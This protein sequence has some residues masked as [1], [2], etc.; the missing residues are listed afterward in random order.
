LNL[1]ASAATVWGLLNIVGWFPIGPTTPEP[2]SST[3]SKWLR[4]VLLCVC[5]CASNYT[6]VQEVQNYNRRVFGYYQSLASV[7]TY[8]KSRDETPRTQP[9]FLSPPPSVGPNSKSPDETPDPGA[10]MINATLYFQTSGEYVASCLQVFDMARSSLSKKLDAQEANSKPIAIVSDLDE[11][12]LDNSAYQSWLARK[13]KGYSEESWQRFAIECQD[14]ISTVPGAVDF[15][16]FAVGKNVRV[17]FVTN[18][19]E[20]LRNA[21]TSTLKRLEL[22]PNQAENPLYLLPNEAVSSDKIERVNNIRESYNV[23][24][25]LGDSLRDFGHPTLGVARPEWNPDQTRKA[26]RL[27]VQSNPSKWGADWIVLPN[28]MYGDWAVRAGKN[29][30]DALLRSRMDAMKD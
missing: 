20:S 10:A 12:L 1:W 30:R 5:Y 22:W 11:T 2:E 16:K 17:F 4:V 13:G 26:I 15:I 21:T 29:P 9:Q 6:Y 23:V 19:R 8:S 28:P 14:D 24:M 3:R 18:R 27:D 25:F 7:G